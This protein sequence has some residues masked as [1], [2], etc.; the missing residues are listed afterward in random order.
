MSNFVKINDGMIKIIANR[1]GNSYDFNI[2]CDEISKINTC[3][4]SKLII[5]INLSLFGLTL[6]FPMALKPIKTRNNTVH[7]V[8]TK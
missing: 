6:D 4:T 7:K 2:P 5:R 8:N 1:G 3:Q